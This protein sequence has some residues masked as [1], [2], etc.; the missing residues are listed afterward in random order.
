MS[1]KRKSGQGVKILYFM[2]L[3]LWDIY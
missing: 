2:N 3:K 1:A